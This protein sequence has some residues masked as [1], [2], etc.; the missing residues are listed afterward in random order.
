VVAELAEAICLDTGRLFS[1]SHVLPGIFGIKDAALSLPCVINKIG[2][3]KVIQPKL[4][5]DEIKALRKSADL[6]ART[7]KEATHA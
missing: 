1:V 7:I 4:N 2:I 6:I 3:S 5:D